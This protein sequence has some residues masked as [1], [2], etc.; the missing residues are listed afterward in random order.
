M[1][2]EGRELVF[3]PQDVRTI[4]TRGDTLKNGAKIGFLTG[5]VLGIANGYTGVECGG[6]FEEGRP[7]DSGEKFTIAAVGAG[8]L[9]GLGA[10]IGTG[11]DALIRGR[12]LLYERP[13]ASGPP[14]VSVE[15]SFAPSSARLQLRVAW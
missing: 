3:A 1:T 4:Y 12:R 6:F 10:A 5:A 14:A 9:G 13:G 15:P 2:V 11:I 7:C 8:V